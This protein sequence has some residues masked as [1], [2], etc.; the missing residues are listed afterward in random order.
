MRIQVAEVTPYGSP[1]LVG[2]VDAQFVG[3]ELGNPLITRIQPHFPL[4]PIMLVAVHDK[5]FRAHAHFQTHLLL[6]LI[7]LEY[8]DLSELDL[9]QPPRE[10]DEEPPF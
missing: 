4:H 3:P 1:I 2:V 7:Q 10:S 6:A 9:S 5:G 8:L